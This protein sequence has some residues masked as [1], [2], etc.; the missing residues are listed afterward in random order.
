MTVLSQAFFTLVRS[1]LV[2]FSFLSAGHCKKLFKGV[3][4]LLIVSSLYLT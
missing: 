4:Y 3:N 2:A 1:H